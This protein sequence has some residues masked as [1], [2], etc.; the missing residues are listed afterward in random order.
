MKKNGRNNGAAKRAASK[1]AARKSA[2]KIQIYDDGGELRELLARSG[3]P[4]RRSISAQAAF[5]LEGVFG[6][7]EVAR[8]EVLEMTGVVTN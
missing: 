1:P 5:L 3:S 2:P 4:H 8:R 7:N 6:T